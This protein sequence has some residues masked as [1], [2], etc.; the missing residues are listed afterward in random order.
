MYLSAAFTTSLSRVLIW[1][2]ILFS[3]LGMFSFRIFLPFMR[4][5]ELPVR[6]SFKIEET[7]DG[8][9]DPSRLMSLVYSWIWIRV[10]IRPRSDNSV[11]LRKKFIFGCGLFL[12]FEYR[13]F[14]I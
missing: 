6:F 11:V 1:L 12:T 10:P 4:A 9:K 8:C 2:S 13:P 14:K 5:C 7:N 3:A